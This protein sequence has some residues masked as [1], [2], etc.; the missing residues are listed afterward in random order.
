VKLFKAFK[1]FAPQFD[2]PNLTEV[3]IYQQ[4]FPGK[5]YNYGTFKNLLHEFNNLAKEFMSYQNYGSD[6]FP[7]MLNMLY[8]LAGR[9]LDRIFDSTLR[10]T[11]QKFPKL[12]NLGDDYFRNNFELE[13]V[14]LYSQYMTG[15]TELEPE[16]RISL[17]ENCAEYLICYTLI[18]LFKLNH[19]IIV[20]S[21][22]KGFD[23]KNNL[24]NIFMH[25]ISNEK[26]MVSIKS[27]APQYY[28][29][30]AIY[31]NN[32][33]IISGYDNNDTYYKEL[34]MLVFENLDKFSRSE[35]FNL[36]I[37]LESRCIEKI[38]GGKDFYDELHEINVLRLEKNLY[39][40][41]ESDYFPVA[42]FRKILSTSIVL[43]KFEWAEYFTKTYIGRLP[44]DHR[45]NMSYYSEALLNF[46]KGIYE[47]ALENIAK[48]T[49]KDYILR[50]NSWILKLKALYELGLFEDALYSL[51]SISQ[52]LLNDTKSPEHE[53]TK[54]FNFLHIYR[55]LLKS[56]FKHEKNEKSE[57]LIPNDLNTSSLQI[58]DN[59]WLL[60]KIREIS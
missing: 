54:V 33:M 38:H 29:V 13:I 3:N 26:L 43:E 17:A 40:L 60:N 14:K 30:I 1:K 42:G 11:E 46:A 58:S 9:K 47:K 48:V 8:E 2:S 27:Y 18:V 21:A 56:K 50:F 53:K 4:V 22:K 44:E 49:F 37:L 5:T 15:A 25:E 41:N 12:E 55:K 34:K 19:D 28:P 45:K 59:K 31:F 36:L 6:S 52:S 20:A 39:S 24:A 7:K 16:K 51:N 23:H 35:R 32:F 57:F 10:E